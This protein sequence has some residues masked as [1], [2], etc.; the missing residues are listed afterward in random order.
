MFMPPPGWY[1]GA[2]SSSGGRCAMPLRLAL[3]LTLAAGTMALAPPLQAA[4]VT[5]VHGVPGFRAD[6]YVNGKKALTGFP[7]GAMTTPIH[8]PA[9]LYHLAIRPAGRR[10]TRRRPRGQ[11]DPD[12]QRERVRGRAPER[13][14][15]AHDLAV[16]EQRRSDRHGPQPAHLPAGRRGPAGRRPRRRQALSGTCRTRPSARRS[17]PRTRTP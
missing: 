9:G 12:G 11:R 3:T 15:Q 7:A 8:L 16:P 1:I 6:V 4:T 17:F 2:S 10:R 5:V 13:A 14:G